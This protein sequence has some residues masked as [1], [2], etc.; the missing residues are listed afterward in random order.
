[1]GEFAF[2]KGELDSLTDQDFR[3]G[4]SWLSVHARSMQSP[5][6]RWMRW[7]TLSRDAE[8]RT[9]KAEQAA[10]QQGLAADNIQL[11]VPEF[12]SILALGLLWLSVDGQRC[13]LQLKP[14]PLGGAATSRIA[15]R[16]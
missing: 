2:S 9:S 12:D 11:G 15:R 10:A 8:A 14:D 4:R 13:L 5:A 16:T 3:P 1:M 6:C 7:Q